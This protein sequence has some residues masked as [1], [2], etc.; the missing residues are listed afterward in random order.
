MRDISDILGAPVTDP[1]EEAF[2][3]FSNSIPSHS[4]GFVDSKASVIDLTVAGRDL[5]IHQSQ[6]LL[7]S[8][9]KEGTTGAVV[10]KVTPLFAGWITSQNF[11]F[12]EGFLTSESIAL[13]LGT[14]VSGIVAL[15]LSTK[16]QRYIATDQ[17]YVIKL[18]KQNISEN[19]R[20]ALSSV[21]NSKRKQGTKPKRSR[22]G[23]SEPSS[24]IDTLVLDWEVDSVR[25]L[26]DH[27]ESQTG[28]SGVDVVIAC[29]CIYNE[30]LIDPFVSCCAE[31]CALRTNQPDGKP[32][33]CIVAQQLRSPEVFELWLRRFHRS[34]QVWRVPDHLLPSSLKEDSGF[35][36]H[37][38]IIR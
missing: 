35:V 24:N 25:S 10:W 11:L 34:F 22:E 21:T 29:D 33:L 38:G 20:G 1:D 14:G 17:G 9:R 19:V 3:V 4:L 30:A 36:I 28:R 6:G 8:N 27:L 7:T 15:T 37:V 13:E 5:S 18:L 16:I 23:V 31:I 32:T 2:L 26:S 12:G